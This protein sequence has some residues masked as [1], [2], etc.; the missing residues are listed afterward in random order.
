VLRRLRREKPPDR[1]VALPR[2][3]ARA[4]DPS[5]ETVFKIKTDGPGD[6]TLRR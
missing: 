1:W 5:I 3:R 2:Y 6:G 4:F